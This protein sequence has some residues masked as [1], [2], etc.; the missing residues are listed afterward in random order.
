MAD[1]IR[2]GILSTANIATKRFIPGVATARNGAVVAIAS[3]DAQRARDA[4]TTL[5]IARAHGS[6]EALLADPEVDAIY[7]PLPNS[8]HA[9]WTLKAAE[10]G[11]PILCEKPLAVD[12]AEAALMVG[13]CKARGVPLMEAFMYRFHP[14]HA[15]VR[16][17]IEAGTIG[18]VRAVRAA[19]TFLLDPFNPAN[20]RLQGSLSGGALMDVGCYA[21]NA[22]RML[23]G[24]EPVGASAT[25]DYREE[26]GVEVTL[27]GVLEFSDRRMATIDC[28]FQA[29]G[30]GWYMVAGTKGRIEVPV[31]F[32]TGEDATTV[33]VQDAEGRREERIPGVNQYTLEA[34]EFADALIEGRPFRIPAEDGVANMRAIDALYRSAGAYGLR[35]DV[36]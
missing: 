34:E 14:Q 9:E 7:N 31:A 12:A 33:I 29:A 4:A 1:R 27:A 28:G 24:E 25:Y 6:Y 20:V 22:A 30:P 15:R 2:W 8:M 11:K 3:R 35:Q 17:L 18:E 5:G 32:V 26:F 36:G 10:A 23:F 16:E 13:G 21:V 19:F